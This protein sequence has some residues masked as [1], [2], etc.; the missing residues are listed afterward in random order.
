LGIEVRDMGYKKKP[1]IIFIMKGFKNGGY[2][3][4]HLSAVPST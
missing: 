4:S 3:L 1:P 2:L